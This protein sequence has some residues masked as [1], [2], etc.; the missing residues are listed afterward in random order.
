MPMVQLQP[1]DPEFIYG[2]SCKLNK[3]QSLSLTDN[4]SALE[5]NEAFK[6]LGVT[7]NQ[8]MTW[9]DHI[10]ILSKKVNQRLGLIRRVKHLLPLQARLTLYNSL[11]LPLLDYGDIVWGD[12]NNAI[13]MDHLQ[14]LQNNA[15]GLV[16]DLPRANSSALQAVNQLN[17][18]P[19]FLP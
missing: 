5:R 4:G 14:V 9:S 18:K 12:K 6:Y 17:W 10:S 15:A 8:S 7:I 19:L 3:F 13:L 2:S 11:I 16:L 1:T